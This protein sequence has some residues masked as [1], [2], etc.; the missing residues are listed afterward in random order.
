MFDLNDS[1][2]YDDHVYGTNQSAYG[3]FFTSVG[4]RLA[5]FA[6][7]RHLNVSLDYDPSFY[8]YRRDSSADNLNQMLGLNVALELSR[9]FQLRVRENASEYYYG[10]FGTGQQLVPGQGPPSGAISYS[11][12]PNVRTIYNFSRIDL[13]FAKSERTVIDVY[14]GYNTMIYSSS[15]INYQGVSGGLSYSYRASRRGSVSLTYSYANSLF[16]TS[17]AVSGSA[18][19]PVSSSATTQGGSRF[20]TQSSFLSYAYKISESITASLFGGPE[21][22]HVR[23]TLLE[24]VSLPIGTIPLLVPVSKFGWE[25]SVGGSVM[26]STQNTVISLSAVRAVSNG[27]GL[28]AAVNS[29]FGSLGISRRLPHDWQWGSMVSYG[30]SQSLPF[31]GLPSSSFNSQIGQASLYRK[32]GEH[33]SFGFDYQYQR[34]RVSGGT[35]LG[36]AALDRNRADVRFD[37]QVK[38]IA[39]HRPRL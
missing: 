26:K 5:L 27:G 19:A 2:G 17:A 35:G 1:T 6:T 4:A 25:W 12:N 10:V 20:T 30:L 38:Q 28:L 8:I 22:T 31:A 18:A 29:N 24:S 13:L 32:L 37:W 21:R 7:R 39:L 14:G 15:F 33:L 34:Q 16:H 36:V 9:R 11:I 23:E 3:D